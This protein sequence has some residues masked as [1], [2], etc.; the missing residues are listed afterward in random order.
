MHEQR[1]PRHHAAR[2]A[3]APCAAPLALHRGRVNS[4]RREK[5]LQ[6]RACPHAFDHVRTERC[7]LPFGVSVWRSC[8]LVRQLG[9]FFLPPWPIRST[10]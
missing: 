3:V 10:V 8:G 4:Q 6:D 9:V 1:R 7:V 5:D 2:R